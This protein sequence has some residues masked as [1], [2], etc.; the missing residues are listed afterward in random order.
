MCQTSIRTGIRL[1]TANQGWE[2]RLD[3]YGKVHTF[4]G[5]SLKECPFRYQGQYED[6]ETGLYYNRFRYYDPSIGAYL[7]Q[8]PIGLAGGNK[9]Y[10]YVHNTNKCMDILGLK[11]RVWDKQNMNFE[12]WFDQASVDDIK[13]NIDDVTS[14]DGLR[15]GGGKHELFP[16]S[17]AP[18][19]KELGFK[20]DELKKMSVDTNKITFVN[21]PDRKTGEIL[22]DGLHHQS[23]ASSH[24][25]YTLMEA[26]ETAGT[27]TEAK[28]IIAQH[29]KN[30]MKLSH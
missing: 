25:H 13:A 23:K 30:H 14:L 7:S 12:T 29:H 3:I 9:L 19:A 24:F 21:V 26:L 27:K 5:R 28:R 20:A 2:A 10:G 8:D 1:R 22:P 16:V 11:E 18:K 17:M 15:A 4:A 6:A